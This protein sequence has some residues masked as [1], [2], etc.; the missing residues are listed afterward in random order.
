LHVSNGWTMP[1]LWSKI[2][3]AYCS[4]LWVLYQVRVFASEAHSSIIA[5]TRFPTQVSGRVDSGL[6]VQGRALVMTSWSSNGP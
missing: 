3:P 2:P 5:G 4:R 6:G 1:V